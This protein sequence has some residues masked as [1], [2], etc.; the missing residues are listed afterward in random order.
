M[1]GILRDDG[2]HREK[3]GAIWRCGWCACL[4][5]MLILTKQAHAQELEVVDIRPF[6]K[7]GVY[8]VDATV[9][10]K[11]SPEAYEAL[12]SGVAL[13]F[14][15]DVSVTKGRKYWYDEEVAA[16]KQRYSLHYHA[17]SDQ[18][19]LNNRNSGAQ[20]SFPTL[21]GALLEMGSIV[22]LPL[23]DDKLLQP[24]EKH[25]GRIR[26]RLDVDSLPTPLRLLAY[27]TAGWH[28]SSEWKTWNVTSAND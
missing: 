24:G 26:A 20:K 18:F 1:L 28:L 10:Y 13:N 17:L 21:K 2:V 27:I 9:F 15:V 5:A 12:D 6:W 3:A 19:I 11:L 4:L 22:A 25:T 23:F 8:Y 7:S 16:L 14:V